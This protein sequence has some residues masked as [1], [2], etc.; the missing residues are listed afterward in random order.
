MSQKAPFIIQPHLSAIAITFRNEEHIGDQ[1]LPHI[2]VDSPEFKYTLFEK[3][4]AFTVPDTRVGRKGRPNEID[5]SASEETESVDDHGLEGTVPYRDVRAA[6]AAGRGRVDP[7]ARNVELVTSL[8]DLAREKRVADTVFNTASYAAANKTDVSDTAENQWDFYGDDTD[9]ASDVIGQIVTARD[10]MIVAPNVF[11]L[12]NKVA[13]A[14]RRH[15]SILKA[16]NGTLGDT[17]MVPLQYLAD[18]F[19]FKRILIGKSRINTAKKGQDVSL[20]RLWG[21]HASML[22]LDP[23]KVTAKEG[24]LTFGFTAD[25]GGRIAGTREDP[26]IGLLGGTRTRVGEMQKQLVV[27]NEAG[28]YF[29]NAIAG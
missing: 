17:G 29:E 4:D 3:G 23:T 18:L 21:N 28:F 20:A 14:L 25:W 13:S 16:F 26:D 12:G 24:G 7:I 2:S 6:A 22:Y 9:P 11:V 19:D 8:V 1:V 5:W 10:D 27:C 15:P